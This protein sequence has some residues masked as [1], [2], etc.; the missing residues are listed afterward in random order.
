[1]HSVV[2]TLCTSLRKSHRSLGRSSKDL[3]SYPSLFSLP[4][5]MLFLHVHPH[6]IQCSHNII[7]HT[8]SLFPS[9]SISSG[10]WA[11]NDLAVLQTDNATNTTQRVTIRDAL[12]IWS[13]PDLTSSLQFRDSCQGPY[14][15]LQC[16]DQFTLGELTSNN[17]PLWSRILIVAIILS[18]AVVTLLFKMLF[19][20][21]L[22][23]LERKQDAYLESLEN[24]YEETDGTLM[25]SV[26]LCVCVCV[27]VCMCVCVSV[28]I[29]VFACISV[30]LL[31]S[32][33]QVIKKH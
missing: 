8:V 32:K 23:V 16:P 12:N 29:H 7:T 21:W 25:V 22:F 5:C 20:C 30:C 2:S 6:C 4:S 14:C 10:R 27:C 11:S 3:G 28:C 13:N 24:D 15:N 31:L 33:L 1:M 26:G 18:I 19:V 17:W 9:H